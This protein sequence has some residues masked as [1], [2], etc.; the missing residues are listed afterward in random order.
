MQLDESLTFDTARS[1]TTK[2]RA[3][4]LAANPVAAT[5]VFHRRIQSLFDKFLFGHTRPF[6]S[7]VGS[8]GRIEQ[9]TRLSPHLHLLLGL[10][11]KSTVLTGNEHTDKENIANFIELF[12][13][14]VI[15]PD[16]PIPQAS[17]PPPT[18]K[19]PIPVYRPYNSK[20]NYGK[21]EI[22]M[23][24]QQRH[25][26]LSGTY[27]KNA[28]DGSPARNKE[29][30]A[31]FIA[32]QLHRCQNYCLKGRASCRFHFPFP[33]QPRGTL[34]AR[35]R[36]SDDHRSIALAPRPHPF[37]NSTHPMI[38]SMFRANTDVTVITGIIAESMY[39]CSYAV[40]ADKSAPFDSNALKKLQRMGEDSSEDRLLLSAIARGPKVFAQSEDQKLLTT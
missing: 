32:T 1:L 19:F 7:I 26:A 34:A 5:T 17:V 28:F 13:T 16:N 33:P 30:R 31:Q 18:Q 27:S 40:K 4:K 37:I 29:L 3:D 14:A 8:L 39:V 35:S 36:N 20:Q 22:L 25:A 21:I 6:G 24:G 2:Q 11:K 9:R 12:C 10:E 15:P 38:T 23:S